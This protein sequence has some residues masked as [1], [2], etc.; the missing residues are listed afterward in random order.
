MPADTSA[1]LEAAGDDARSE[2]L[3]PALAYARLDWPVLPLR[4]RQKVPLPGS[5]G[6]HDAT[7][8]PDLIR[9]WWSRQP[10]ANIGLAAGAA[11]WVLDV[12]YGGWEA[13]G[14]D[15]AD[16]F[17]L[18]T[19]RYGRLPETVQQC[20]GGGGWQYLFQPDERI[21]NGVRFLPGLDTRGAG[22]YVV[23]PPSIHPSGNTYRWRRGH[24]PGDLPLA[25]APEW[26]VRLAEPVELAAAEPARS[27]SSPS[28]AVPS[29]RY[30]AAALEGACSAI[31]TASVGC[32]ADTL[33]RQGYGIGR[34]IAGKV[35][36]SAEAR[37]ALISA[38]RRMPNARGR[39]PWTDRE[40]AFRIDRAIRQ[41]AN[42]PRVPEG[43]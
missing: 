36:A 40:I 34:L 12:D 20:T 15:G 26:L 41:A 32:Q 33:D 42:H 19:K 5:R 9:P 6:V 24:A 11:F 29:D 38:G 8:D 17:A 14:P 18:L 22:G 43:R 23:A 4:P 28:I 10:T 16:S 21:G 37:A 3:E 35:L 7:T 13:T 30:A 25:P 39:R 27:E 2:F 1:A 31:A